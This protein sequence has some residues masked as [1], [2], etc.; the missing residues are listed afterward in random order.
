MLRLLHPHV[1]TNRSRKWLGMKVLPKSSLSSTKIHP[2]ML[3]QAD[4]TGRA[5]D[6]GQQNPPV[7]DLMMTEM[8]H[9]TSPS[10]ASHNLKNLRQRERRRDRRV[11]S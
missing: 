3:P 2:T 7:E 6:F 11:F 5:R 8:F 9:G 1:P 4:V 10:S